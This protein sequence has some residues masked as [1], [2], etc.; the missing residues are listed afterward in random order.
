[1]KNKVK[2]INLKI[3]LV[4]VVM[5]WS[6]ISFITVKNKVN[7]RNQ[8]EVENLNAT[9]KKQEIYPQWAITIG[10]GGDESIW[11]SSD[12]IETNDGGYVIAGTFGSS[13]INLGNNIILNNKGTNSTDGMII[14]YDNK[15]NVE[16]AKSLGGE[17]N[18]DI[19][20]LV[21]DTVDEGYIVG[22]NFK[23]SSIELENNIVLKNR[24]SYD[25]MIIKYNKNGVLQWEKV[26]G[27]NGWDSIV[28]IEPTE[29]GGYL[30]GGYFNSQ[31]ISLGNGV[32][33]N[34]YKG[35]ADGFV[36]KYNKDGVA[37]WGKV[38]GGDGY[39]RIEKVKATSDGGCIAVG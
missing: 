31:A 17:D 3:I 27:D 22:G 29:E 14:K 34:N 6:V 11:C 25:G 18:E 39:E 1:M 35:P 15:R 9:N 37:Q 5:L 38:I 33:L 32:I 12:K 10:G 28:S 36:I 21:I 23:S 13:S 20:A 30:V 16:W 26:I 2:K 8:A 4:F 7:T 24:G 19:L